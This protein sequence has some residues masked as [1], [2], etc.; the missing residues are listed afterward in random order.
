M[1]SVRVCLVIFRKS[2]EIVD[3][4]FLKLLNRAKDLSSTQWVARLEFSDLAL[5]REKLLDSFDPPL[6]TGMCS[7]F[8]P[9]DLADSI[10]SF[11]GEQLSDLIV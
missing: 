4:G 2:E 11:H 1:R 3:A 9:Q 7:I 6:L 10:I 5:N 8:R